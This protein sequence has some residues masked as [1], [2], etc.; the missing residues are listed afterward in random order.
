MFMPNL[1]SNVILKTDKNDQTD[2]TNLAIPQY[3]L[4]FSNGGS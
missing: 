2:L 4:V 1:S 3:S